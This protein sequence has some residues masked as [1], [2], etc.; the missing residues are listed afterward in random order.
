M[1]R[2]H[3]SRFLRQLVFFLGLL[4]V[5]VLIQN[6]LFSQEITSGKADL[7]AINVL[8]IDGQGTH[9]W[10]ESTPVLERDLEETGLFDVTVLTTPPEWEELTDF[11]PNFSDFDVV[12]LNYCGAEWPPQAQKAFLEFIAGGGGLVLVHSANL[13]FPDWAEFQKLLC[14]SGWNG[15]DDSYGPYRYWDPEQGGVHLAKGGPTGTQSGQH[16]YVIHSTAPNHPIMRGISPKMLHSP[17]ELYANLRGIP[18]N[19]PNVT[20]LATAFSDPEHK[21]SGRH[22]IQLATVTYGKGRV[23]QILYGNAGKQCRSVAFIV[24]FIRGTQ[25]AATGNVTIPIPEDIPTEDKSYVRP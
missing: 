12:V 5:S 3:I 14:V 1:K 2:R 6:P 20:I 8:L 10:R 25:W 7:S 11:L 24:P 4:P 18:Q 17:D 19:A 15:R 9:N 22:E 23:F 16:E 21:G 13:A